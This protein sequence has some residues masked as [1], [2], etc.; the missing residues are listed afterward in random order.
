MVKD[1]NSASYFYSY[2]TEN[3]R[4]ACKSWPFLYLKTIGIKCYTVKRYRIVITN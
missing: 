3:K 1:L 2:Q 4:P